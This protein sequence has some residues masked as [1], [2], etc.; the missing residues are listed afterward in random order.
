MR[1]I[2]KAYDVSVSTVH[3]VLKRNNIERRSGAPSAFFDR[4]GARALRREYEAGA[5]MEELVRRHGCGTRAP[6]RKALLDAGTTLR[7]RGARA[8]DLTDKE[9]QQVI[10]DWTSGLSKTAIAARLGIST[11][12]VGRAL[13]EAGV[14]HERRLSRR[15]NHRMWKGGRTVRPGGYVL[16]LIEHDDPM[17]EMRDQH[18]YVPEH[19]LVMAR[20]LGRPLV[21]HE[22]VH[23]V[24]GVRDDNRLQN[25][26][27]R[28]GKHGNGVRMRC[29]DCGSFNVEAVTFDKH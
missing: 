23:H 21:R 17:A 29:C 9:V 24:N 20:D 28:Q 1:R 12:R 25:L 14:D 3:G 26:Q 4:E 5:S 6:V 15:E 11:V 19:R 10:V 18:G 13:D 7:N 8:V 16:R 27:L 22:T 2:A